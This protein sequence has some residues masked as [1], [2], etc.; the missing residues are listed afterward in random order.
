M[1]KTESIYESYVSY[2]ESK[3]SKLIELRDE[4]KAAV[5]AAKDYF[6]KSANNQRFLWNCK[7]RFGKTF[8]AMELAI[9]MGESEVDSNGK[10][11]SKPISRVLIITHKPVVQEGFAIDLKKLQES[12]KAKGHLKR[13]WG[14]GTRSEKDDFGNF[15]DLEKNVKNNNRPYV[16][17]SSTQWLC[18]SK[19]VGGTI[20]DPLRK[21]IL[22]NDW[23]L[24]VIDEA[25]EGV[26]ADR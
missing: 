3:E 21:A 17:F 20:D 11:D 2:S 18:Y 10:K 14:F 5:K 15:Y 7:M 6:E 4:Q 16:F 9:E 8:C 1:S 13:E 23:D 26:L 25:H 22:N 12:L 24:V 19:E